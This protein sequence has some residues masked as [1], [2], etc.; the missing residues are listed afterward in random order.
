[1]EPGLSEIEVKQ[2][3]GSL[4]LSSLRSLDVTVDSQ[5]EDSCTAEQ[6]LL[7]LLASTGDDSVVV[8]PCLEV[9]RVSSK[10]RADK[11]AAKCV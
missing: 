9:L 6:L 3:V 11:D 2:L 1:M 8:C 7:A 10:A 4:S 5:C